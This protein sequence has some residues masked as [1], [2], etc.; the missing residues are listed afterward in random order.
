M[1]W[2]VL[3]DKHRNLYTQYNMKTTSFW[4]LWGP[5][6][7]WAYMNAT[8]RGKKLKSPTGNIHQQG[9]NVLLDKQGLVKLHHVGR[10]PADRPK[11]DSI[12]DLIRDS[13]L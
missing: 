9:G 10:G 4:D 1:D 11:V 3:S 2:P 8:F 7:W 5:K 12:I 13:E 6:T